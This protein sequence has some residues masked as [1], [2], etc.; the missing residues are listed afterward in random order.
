M[1]TMF[2]GAG[3]AEG[4]GIAGLLP[5]LEIGVDESG[6]RP[7]EV[8]RTVE[9]VLGSIGLPAT[10][11]VLLLVVVAGMTL[12]GLLKWLA[13][14]EAGFVTARVGM[15]L[16][17]R[18]IRSLMAAEWA[19]FT[20][21]PTGHFSNAISTEAHR[22]AMGYREACA[23]LAGLIQVAVYAAFVV[24]IS[25]KIA[26]AA[27]VAGALIMFMLR[28]LVATARSA[29]VDQAQTMR[30]LVARLTEA[31]PGI[32][33][34]KAMAREPFLLPLLEHETRGYN[35]AQRRQVSAIESLLAFQEPI[36]VVVLSLGLYAILTYTSIAFSSVLVLA[37]LF[38]RLVGGLN[39]TQAKYQ[40]M[41]SG[42]GAFFSI[43]ELIA[44]AEDARE[45]ERGQRPAPPSIEDG[46]VIRDLSFSYEGTRVLRGVNLEI[47]SGCFVAL[48]GVSGSGKTTLADLIT[49]LLTPD[50]GEILVDGV[51]LQSFDI[52]SWRRG[53]GYVPQ[54]FLLFHDTVRRNVTLGNEEISDEEVERALRAADAWDFVAGLPAG[55]DQLVG[56]R[57][58]KLSGGQ[59][60]RI[61]IARAIVEH[62]RLLILDE[63]TTALDPETE[64]EICR[65]LVKLKDEVT[66]LTISHQLAM[67]DVADL[68]FEVVDGTVRRVEDAEYEGRTTGKRHGPV[69]VR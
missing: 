62:P 59:R 34:V 8:S 58:A 11:P 6:T 40:S 10:L 47:P 32:K 30:R 64:A 44:G 49:G 17:L 9:A 25:W 29:G 3:L 54:E 20:S 36:L 57:G 38:Y 15:D 42:E 41:A 66:I 5:I 1:V 2:L 56:E 13:M 37:F 35:R 69:D 24:F 4:V 45:T 50:E 26:A 51:P 43:E 55:L 19:F 14:R 60:Q 27:L 12:K 68:L 65:T 53:I 16:R 22:A 31:L 67:R 18:L 7:S 46:I 23:A 52:R 33:P 21:S 28:R 61:A 48:V 63:A 39:L